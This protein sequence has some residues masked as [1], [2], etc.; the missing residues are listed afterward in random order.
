MSQI[1][2]YCN[3][4]FP[5]INAAGDG[6]FGSCFWHIYVLNSSA[7]GNLTFASFVFRVVNS[8]IQ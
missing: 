7:L 1:L 4:K 2:L 6:Y 8:S 5:G 3:K